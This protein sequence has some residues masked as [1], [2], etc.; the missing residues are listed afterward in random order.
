M[1]YNTKVYLHIRLDTGQ[2]FYVGMGGGDRPWFKKSR[3]SFWWA[4]ANK[5][6]YR[7]VVIEDCLTWEQACEIEIMLVAHYG[8]RDLGKGPLVNLTNGGDGGAQ[9]F[10][11]S[12]RKNLSDAQI[13]RYEDPAEREKRRQLTLKF[14]EDPTE[15]ERQ[16]KRQLDLWQDPSEREKRVSSIKRSRSTA[17]SR[18][19]T[20]EIN[21]ERYRDPDERKRQS[22]KQLVSRG[23]PE[24]RHKTRLES[25]GRKWMND[26]SVNKFVNPNEISQLLAEGWSMGKLNRWIN[27]GVTSLSIKLPELPAYLEQ[28]WQL[29]RL[30]FTA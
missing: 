23:T 29:G 7:V 6:G 5:A 14:Y 19:K 24:S 16:S 12:Y 13:K 21:K 28:G 27:N 8:R 11:E 15:R 20:S 22:D 1:V 2:V 30:S 25:T 3:N 10:T 18:Q 9:V 26:G 4:I 17:E